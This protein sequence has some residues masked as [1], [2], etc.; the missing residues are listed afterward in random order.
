MI[1]SVELA[2]NETFRTHMHQIISD[3][4]FIL[5]FYISHKDLMES[6]FT[7]E[8]KIMKNLGIEFPEEFSN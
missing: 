8:I 4:N 1:S 6:T 7:E 3:I 5:K 2:L